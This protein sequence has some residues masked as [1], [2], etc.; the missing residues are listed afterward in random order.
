SHAVLRGSSHAELRESS[1]AELRESSH[2]VLLG[3]S[4]AVLL[5]SS[6]A[7]LRESSHAELRESSHAVLRGSSHAELWEQSTAHQKSRKAPELHG[8][9]V[10]FLYDGYAVPI[11]KSD[12]ATIIQVVNPKSVAD[13]LE[14]EGVVEADGKVVLYKRVSKNFLTQEHKPWETT[15]VIGEV[16]THPNW[17]PTR[18]ECGA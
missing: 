16:K 5:G 3:S 8:Q 13:W 4:H 11:R 1:H 7:E 2:A 10:C 14:K 12:N 17:N 9:A 18:E 6:H 15:W